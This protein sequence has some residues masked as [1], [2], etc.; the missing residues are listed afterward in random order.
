MTTKIAI[1]IQGGN[2]KF[3]APVRE[4][5]S[6]RFEVREINGNDTEAIQ[7]ALAWADLTWV[8][9]VQ[10]VAVLVS[11]MERRGKLVMRLHSFEAYTSLPAEVAWQNVDAL[12][13]VSPHVTD[14][15]KLRIPDIEDRTTVFVMPNCIDTDSF[16]IP[17]NKLRTARSLCRPVTP[18]QELAAGIAVLCCRA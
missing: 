13:V 12:M 5:L 2:D 11:Q 9:W 17:A 16:V 6:P 7:N 15:L 8:E 10:D 18:Y 4:W 3:L 1:I 14:I